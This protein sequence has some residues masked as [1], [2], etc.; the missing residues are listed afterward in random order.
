MWPLLVLPSRTV[1]AVLLRFHVLS[2]HLF[3]FFLPC[4][5]GVLVRVR[6]EEGVDP[7]EVEEVAT[8]AKSGR[9]GCKGDFAALFV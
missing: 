4:T 7:R 8:R 9:L 1:A 6:S 3:L 5:S 2:H